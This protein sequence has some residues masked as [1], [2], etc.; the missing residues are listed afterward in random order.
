MIATLIALTLPLCLD[1]FLIAATIG[2]SRPSFQKRLRI[3]A[4]FASFEGG[5]PLVGLALG[6]ALSGPLG[7]GAEYIA[8]A[9]LVG[10]GLYTI[11][12]GSKEDESAQQLLNAQGLAIL[13]LGLGISLDGLAIGFTYGVLHLPVLLT[14]S[15]ILIQAF[16]VCQLGFVVG[17]SIAPRFREWGE[18]LAGW[19]LVGIGLV[20]LWQKLHS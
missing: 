10:F 5:M 6:Q 17:G 4:F 19:A 12:N 11:F 3:S 9:I 20:L 2:L 7:G 1:S 15:V 8:I 16:L 14:T 13:A 18:R